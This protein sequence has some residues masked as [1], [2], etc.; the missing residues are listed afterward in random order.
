MAEETT[1]TVDLNIHSTGVE[2]PAAAMD[3]FLNGTDGTGGFLGTSAV[4]RLARVMQI[5]GAG[6]KT[7]I[8]TGDPQAG[9]VEDSEEK[10]VGTP[11]LTTKTLIP[12]TLAVIV[13]M[14]NRFR[15]NKE[16]LANYIMGDLP[17]V[18]AEKFDKTVLQGGAP[19]TTGSNGN[20]AASNGFDTLQGAS[21]VV[22]DGGS[23]YTAIAD[24]MSSIA[25]SGGTMSG[26]ILSPQ[27]N[28]AVMKSRAKDGGLEFP[29][30][31]PG[32]GQ[33]MGLPCYTS[34]AA[35][36]SSTTGEDT[37]SSNG[38]NTLG[39]AGDWSKAVVGI[40]NDVSIELGEHSI[41]NGKQQVNLWQRN[42]FAIRAEM[43][44]GFV[45]ADTKYFQRLTDK[46]E[47]ASTAKAGTAKTGSA[48]AA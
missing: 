11:E 1:K 40:V 18:L 32:S 22:A 34:N 41:T 26:F 23:M 3:L 47:T 15:A 7:T 30:Y 6:V 33:L 48:K 16:A 35:Y 10:P 36:I 46:A 37:S 20:T 44:V 29:G 14:S 27:G 25:T 4:A 12:Y 28:A 2:I 5:P 42:M 45:V 39:F 21:A 43:E 17:R 38:A 13:P 24:A 31:M 19:G 9:W 8:V